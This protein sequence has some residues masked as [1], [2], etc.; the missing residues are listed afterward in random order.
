MPHPLFQLQCKT[1]RYNGNA[2]L[3]DITL[4][5]EHGERI[6]IIGKSGAGKSTLLQLL[7]QQSKDIVTLIPQELGLVKNLSVFHNIYMGRLHRYSS[8]YNLINLVKPLRHELEDVASIAEQLRLKNKLFSL[9]GELSG[10]QQQRTAIGRALFNENPVLIGD[11]PVSAIDE[12]QARNVLQQIN[13]RHNTVI[14][15]MHDTNL[16][17]MYTNRIIGIRDGRIVLDAPSRGMKVDDL[18][19]LYQ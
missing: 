6:A 11:E 15:A 10:G 19:P 3:H 7:Y 12:H 18:S 14:L 2:V 17:L 9:A 13:N 5:I 4:K 1:G 8:I 16:A